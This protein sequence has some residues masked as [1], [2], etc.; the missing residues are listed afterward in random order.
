MDV[1]ESNKMIDT[2][3]MTDIA[4][5]DRLNRYYFKTLFDRATI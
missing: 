3:D 2:V 1:N 4:D 5:I